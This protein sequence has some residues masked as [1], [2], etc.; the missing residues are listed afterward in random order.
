[1]GKDTWTPPALRL[2]ATHT[3]ARTYQFRVQSRK[4]GSVEFGDGWALCTV[5]DKTGELIVVSDWGNWA[6]RWDASPRNLGERTFTE[7]LAGRAMTWTSHDGKVLYDSYIATKLTTRADR[8]AFDDEATAE[9]LCHLIAERR[10]RDGRAERAGIE[11]EFAVKRLDREAARELFDAIRGLVGTVGS[12]DADSDLF[13]SYVCQTLKEHDAAAYDLL[14]E[15]W[16]HLEYKPTYPYRVLQ[17]AILPALVEA[18]KQTVA[19]ERMAAEVTARAAV[20]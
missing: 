2:V 8:E 14:D 16:N 15:P 5:N 7:F 4:P 10:L 12:G 19:D 20:Q 17:E 18:C 9:A 11:G 1:M 13:L 3:A 6:Y